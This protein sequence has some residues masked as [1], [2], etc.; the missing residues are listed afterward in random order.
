MRAETLALLHLVATAER[1]VHIFVDNQAV[2]DGFENLL[3]EHPPPV[4]G[5][6]SD[7]W[8]QIHRVFLAKPDMFCVQKVESHLGEESIDDGRISPTAE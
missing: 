7:L 1:P 4:K 5:S 8:S 6:Q 3:A 2:V